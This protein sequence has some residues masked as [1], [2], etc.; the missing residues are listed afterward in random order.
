MNRYKHMNTDFAIPPEIYIL[1]YDQK[2]PNAQQI[3][4]LTVPFKRKKKK[5]KDRSSALR[6]NSCQ[7]KRNSIFPRNI[8]IKPIY[9]LKIVLY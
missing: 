9:L 1:F 8:K 7:I 3:Q 6:N 4:S 2:Q 5:Q